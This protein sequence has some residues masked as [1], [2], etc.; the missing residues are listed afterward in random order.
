MDTQKVTYNKNGHTFI[1]S[2]TAGMEDRL[3]DEIMQMAEGADSE[4]DWLDAATLSF[5]I[6]K[7]AAG[8]HI[9]DAPHPLMQKNKN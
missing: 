6:A 7:V 2:Y 1:F 5:Q 4:L 8:P 9:V 3:V